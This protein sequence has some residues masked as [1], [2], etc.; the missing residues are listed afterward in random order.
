MAKLTFRTAEVRE[1]VKHARAS[2]EHQAPYGLGDPSPGLFLVKDEGV[3]LMS[4]GIPSQELPD[5]G[6]GKNRVKVAYAV[7]F[8]PVKQDRMEVYDRA[9]AAVGGDDF[10]EFVPL[11]MIEQVMGGETVDLVLTESDLSLERQGIMAETA[12]SEWRGDVCMALRDRGHDD[13]ADEFGGYDDGTV[14]DLYERWSTNPEAAAQAV[15][16]GD[17]WP[18]L[19]GK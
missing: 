10:I 1:L 11:D 7:G 2:E 18:L 8:D 12:V 5:Q 19:G 9:R 6:N 15:A 13:L 16:A 4:N 17:W 3:Y 14:R